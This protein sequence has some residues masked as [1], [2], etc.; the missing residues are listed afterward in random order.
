M[1]L[2]MSINN[3][4]KGIDRTLIKSAEDI[5]LGRIAKFLDNRVRIHKDLDRLEHWDECIKMQFSS[6]YICKILYSFEN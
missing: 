5:K 1:I 6:R 4:K 3:L 2:N